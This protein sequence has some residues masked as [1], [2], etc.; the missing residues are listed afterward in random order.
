MGNFLQPRQRITG[1]VGATLRGDDFC[2]AP[3]PSQDCIIIQEL[4]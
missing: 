1:N 4:V 3:S 2:G